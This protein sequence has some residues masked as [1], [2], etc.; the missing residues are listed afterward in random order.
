MAKGGKGSTAKCYRCAGYLCLLLN[1]L[2][3][4]FV[5]EMREI[6]LH[7]Q[8]VLP[9]NAD[10][11]GPTFG[12]GTVHQT[13]NKSMHLCSQGHTYAQRAC[14]QSSTVEVHLGIRV[15]D[16]PHVFAGNQLLTLDE[17][18]KLLKETGYPI[19]CHA[20]AHVLNKDDA[21]FHVISLRL[22]ARTG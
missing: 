13:L 11:T 8:A 18:P 21:I 1:H 9:P 6:A 16:H 20:Q 17:A 19:G 4:S 14:R 15:L 3:L 12:K 7:F 2:G 22:H 5:G 10:P